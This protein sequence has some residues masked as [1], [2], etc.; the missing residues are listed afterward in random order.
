MLTTEVEPFRPFGSRARGTGDGAFGEPQRTFAVDSEGMLY[1]S[2]HLNDRIQV[3]TG[4]GQLIDSLGKQGNG[5][6][7][8]Q[9]PEGVHVC[10]HV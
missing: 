1:I 9:I 5:Q 4:D 6:E 3:F 2:D 7:K 8:L 10:T